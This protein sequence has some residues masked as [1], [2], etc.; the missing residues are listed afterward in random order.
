MIHDGHGVETLHQ[1]ASPLGRD[2]VGPQ[3]QVEGDV[4]LL[5]EP[6]QPCRVEIEPAG[7]AKRVCGVQH[8]GAEAFLFQPLH[9]LVDRARGPGGDG[10]HLLPVEE[11]HPRQGAEQ[12]RFA[13]FGFHSSASCF[14]ASLAV[15][16]WTSSCLACSISFTPLWKSPTFLWPSESAKS[17]CLPETV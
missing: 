3:E 8:G 15:S 14:L 17:A 16:C 2:G 7:R 11:W 13:S 6:A 10:R 1:A 9:G 12:H 5:G 4:L